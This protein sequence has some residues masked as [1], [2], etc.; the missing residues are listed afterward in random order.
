MTTVART[1]SSVH[2]LTS[3]ARLRPAL[4]SIVLRAIA[5]ITG[6]GSVLLS[7]I[8]RGQVDEG[9]DKALRS[10]EQQLSFRLG[11]D[12]DLDQLPQAYL[13]EMAPFVGQMPFFTLDGG[14]LSKPSSRKLVSLRQACVKSPLPA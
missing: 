5:G 6:S 14:D 12:E 1:A 7:D 4:A 3:R 9:D 11:H 2:S 8:V 10:A 13:Q